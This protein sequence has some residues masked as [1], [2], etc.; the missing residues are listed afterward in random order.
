MPDMCGDCDRQ[1]SC[2]AAN[3]KCEAKLKD[4][5]EDR[6]AEL[7]KHGLTPDE[8]NA[9][10]ERERRYIHELSTICDPAGMVQEIAALKDQVSQLTAALKETREPLERIIDEKLGVIRAGMESER[11]LKA[12]VERLRGAFMLLQTAIRDAY[13]NSRLGSRA[14][15]AVLLGNI[16]AALSGKGEE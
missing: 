11:K 7:N 9:L 14:T 13:V 12:E 1:R 6:I 16:N 4:E 15:M 8:I 5:A 2:A 3:T 10:P